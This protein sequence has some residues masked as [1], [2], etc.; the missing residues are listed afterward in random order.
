MKVVFLLFLLLVSIKNQ[1][2]SIDIDNA[3]NTR[4]SPYCSKSADYVYTSNIKDLNTIYFNFT[5]N[6]FDLDSE[7]YVC[8]TDVNPFNYTYFPPCFHQAKISNYAQVVDEYGQKLY[9]YKYNSYTN[10]KYLIVHYR[11]KYTSGYLYV[12]F[13]YDDLYEL[14]IK[15]DLTVLEII[16]IVIGSVAILIIIIVVIVRIK[17]KAKYNAINNTQ[18]STTPMV[19]DNIP[20]A[21][22]V[23][24]TLYTPN[25]VYPSG[26]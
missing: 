26:N 4:I 1:M 10:K 21:P 6:R 14:F 3:V 20:S 18:P 23:N 22:I 16:F 8:Y 5:D 24:E 15:K 9:F 25:P 13:S 2:T 11:G 17:R 7:M 12:R 19:I